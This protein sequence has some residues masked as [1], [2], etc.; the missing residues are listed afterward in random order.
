VCQTKIPLSHSWHVS[1]YLATINPSLCQTGQGIL[2]S[3]WGTNLSLP[4]F[5]FFS[6]MKIYIVAFW[7][8]TL[9]S[10]TDRKMKVK[11]QLCMLQSHKSGGKAPIIFNLSTRQGCLVKF[12]AP[13]ALLQ[14]KP[15]VP[16]KYETWYAPEL[17]W[18]L[19]RRNKSLAPVRNHT[20]RTIL[21]TSSHHSSYY[22][23]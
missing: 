2:V 12:C 14:C 6:T 23:D 1:H 17:V 18:M 11:S 7:V 9:C 10:S 3:F 16:I 15:L 22:N 13:V 20:T 8:I 19:G 21:Q 4:R 5:K